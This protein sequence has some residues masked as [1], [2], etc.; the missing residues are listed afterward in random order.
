MARLFV[1]CVI[2]GGFLVWLGTRRLK[3]TRQQGL[4]LIL[5]GVLL[6][7]WWVVFLVLD[8]LKTGARWR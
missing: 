8:S 6:N 7:A 5:L 4:T 2:V 3:K 1:L